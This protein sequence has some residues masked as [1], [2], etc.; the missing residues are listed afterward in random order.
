ML[1]GDM[2]KAKIFLKFMERGYDII[3]DKF[4]NAENHFQEFEYMVKRY[5]SMNDITL[6][7]SVFPEDLNKE[8][9]VNLEEILPYEANLES[10]IISMIKHFRDNKGEKYS[11]DNLTAAVMCHENTIVFFNKIRNKLYEA[12]KKYKGDISKFKEKMLEISDEDVRP[13]YNTWQDIFEGLTIALNDTWAYEVQ[14]TEYQLERDGTYKGKME[15]VIYD[16]FGLDKEDV[17][18]I[19]KPACWIIGFF[20]WFVLQHWDGFGG[21][22][23]P[24]VTVIKKELSFKGNCKKD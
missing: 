9:Y 17:S 16:H 20:H 22:Y 2:T 23:R 6:Y 19:L 3:S 11:D 7:K 24:F 4:E 1:Y 15:I 18:G 12:L 8:C 21:K 14:I 10:N 5:F 13:V